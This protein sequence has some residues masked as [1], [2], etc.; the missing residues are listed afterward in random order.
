MGKV[1][2]LIKIMPADENVDLDELANKISKDL[3]EG[4]ELRESRKEPLAFGT[5]CLLAAF[6]VPD[7]EGYVH[8]LEN[9]LRSFSEIQEF[10]TEFVTRV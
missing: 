2:M 1:V 5:E 4:I 3:P 7:E 8:T 6:I 10:V 9:Y